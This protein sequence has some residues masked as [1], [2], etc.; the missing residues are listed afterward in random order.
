MAA[1]IIK[2]F[3]LARMSVSEESPDAPSVRIKIEK[4]AAITAADAA[5][6]EIYRRA[7][8][9]DAFGKRMASELGNKRPQIPFP[10]QGQLH[11][12]LQSFMKQD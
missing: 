3:V 5:S 9:N 1:C 11:E 4:P 12:F 7:D 8:P 6:V 10:L 2:Y